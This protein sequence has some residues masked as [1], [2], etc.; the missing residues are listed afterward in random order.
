M[1]APM[2]RG[3]NH[4][5][6][7]GR[8]P[9]L[10]SFRGRQMGRLL[11]EF[12]AGGV[13]QEFDERLFQSLRAPHRDD[14][15]RRVRDQDLARIHQRNAVA[16]HGLIHEVGRNE[17]RDV[18]LAGEVD[19]DLPELVALD[20]VD[21]RRRLVQDQQRRGVVDHRHRELETLTHAQGQRVGQRV[22]DP[23]EVEAFRRLGDAALD[24]VRRQAVQTGV[25]LE[26]L[27]D[28]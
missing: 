5:A 16:P 9:S 27:P 14:V 7:G 24:P 18:V 1:Y 25:Q 12:L 10:P 20:R 15:L 17:D 21:S 28:A 11:P 6:C 22:H 2:R 26:V 13:L 23:G 19:E 3:L 4:R 8:L